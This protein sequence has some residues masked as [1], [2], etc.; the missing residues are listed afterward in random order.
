M[1]DESTVREYR[2]R[3][4]SSRV[5]GRECRECKCVSHYLALT[6]SRS[7]TSSLSHYL[8]LTLSGSLS[9]TLS[10]STGLTFPA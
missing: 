8:T 1:H 3:V 2:F 4:H 10:G 9:L 7:H 6:L 5:K